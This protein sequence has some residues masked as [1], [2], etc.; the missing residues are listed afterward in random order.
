[1]NDASERL[2]V[3]FEERSKVFVAVPGMKKEREV[4]LG[5]EFELRREVAAASR[6]G[7]SSASLAARRSGQKHAYRS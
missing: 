3:G 2:A 4:V 6:G 1:V 5:S 7:A